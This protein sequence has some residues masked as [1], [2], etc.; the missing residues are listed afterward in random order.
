M[1]DI[2]EL[3]L[4]LELVL[5]KS[6]LDLD[7]NLNK[8]VVINNFIF[9]NEQVSTILCIK[10]TIVITIRYTSNKIRCSRKMTRDY[11]F[12]DLAAP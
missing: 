5:N 9:D 12:W 8:I 1:L 2:I 10:T 4:D 3:Y 7:P 6:I 11:P